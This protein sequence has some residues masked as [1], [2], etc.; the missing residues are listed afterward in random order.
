MAGEAEA[1]RAR[2]TGRRIAW[3]IAATLLLALVAA[4]VLLLQAGRVA[5]FALD[6]AGDA[7]GLEITAEGAA[8]Y[9]L[10]G[11]PTLVVRDLRA[12]MPGAAVPVLTADR[13]LLSLPWST[14]RGRLRD[15][16]FTRVELDAPVLRLEALQA[17]LATRPPGDGRVPTLREGLAVVDGTVLAE[18]WR[19]EEI[20][21][22]MPLLHPDRPVR[23]HATGRYVAGATALPFDLHVAMQRPAPG[24]ALGIA[25]TATLVREAWRIPARV[26]LHGTWQAGDTQAPF[27]LG[28]AAPL[29]HSAGRTTLAPLHV[30]V[31][32]V[33]SNEANPIPR[34][35][36][37]GSLALADALDLRLAGTLARWPAALPAL[38]PP[39]DD[40]AAPTGFDLRYVGDVALDDVA[41]LTATRGN[42]R[43]DARLRLPAITG[44]L[45][46]PPGGT[47]LPPLDATASIPR[48]EVAG[49]TLHG[50]ELTLDDPAIG[51]TSA[52]RERT[53]D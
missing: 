4:L 2:G 13:L 22:A 5:D 27:A 48:L 44:W 15:L 26:R 7:L 10:R 33:D 23:A 24:S 49:A 25:G 1:P 21:L 3:I 14:L 51:E 32:P 42:A 18:G 47:P 46:A 40:P 17:W 29:R 50:V 52:E 45:D 39:L 35:E 8:E 37:A 36:A 9:R 6:R 53:G 31:R 19:V 16:H 11:T 43:A 34:L 30:A 38:P 12:R 28:L 20:D 41:E